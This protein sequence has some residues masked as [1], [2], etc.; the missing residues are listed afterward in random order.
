MT[1]NRAMTFAELYPTLSPKELKEAENNFTRYLE[2]A[3]EIVR[4]NVQKEDP[5]TQ[6]ITDAD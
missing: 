6:D 4:E 5:Q 1:K 2:I 3:L